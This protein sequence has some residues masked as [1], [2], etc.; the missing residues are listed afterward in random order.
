MTRTRTHTEDPGNG[1][2]AARAALRA[3]TRA[4]KRTARR[5]A[6]TLLLR[7]FKLAAARRPTRRRG[8]PIPGA[9]PDARWPGPGAGRHGGCAGSWRAPTAVISHPLG[10]PGVPSDR[11]SP[12]PGLAHGLWG[13]LGEWGWQRRGVDAG[14][15]C[16]PEAWRRW[17]TGCLGNAAGGGVQATRRR[18]PRSLSGCRRCSGL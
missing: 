14:R 13:G 10:R 1:R 18:R 7:A 15:A 11:G 2:C 3:S 4:R 6:P 12:G 5:A 17:V 9:R 16:G 8:R